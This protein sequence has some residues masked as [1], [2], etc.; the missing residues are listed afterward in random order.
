MQNPWLVQA[1]LFLG[2]TGFSFLLLRL[3][4][5]YVA[6]GKAMYAVVPAL[7]L[8]GVLS[9]V[10]FLRLKLADL[11]IWHLVFLLMIFVGWRQKTRVEASRLTE[12]AGQAAQQ[13]GG[14]AAEIGSTFATGR[15]ML[16]IGFACY[17][18]AFM[19]TFFYMFPRP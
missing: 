2:F 16:T 9:A 8:F 15:Q 4:F 13:T 19:A 11:L 12:L 5:Q 7:A 1:L 17:V 18:V 6:Q 10:V 3:S 14:D